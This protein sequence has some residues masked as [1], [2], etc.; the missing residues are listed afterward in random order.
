MAP[1]HLL[2]RAGL[3]L[4]R[5][6]RRKSDGVFFIANEAHYDASSDDILLVGYDGFGAR[7]AAYLREVTEKNANSAAGLPPAAAA[8]RAAPIASTA[9]DL[10]RNHPDLNS[11][12]GQGLAAARK[13]DDVPAAASAGAAGDPARRTAE[14]TGGPEFPPARHFTCADFYTCPI[15]TKEDIA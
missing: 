13:G 3:L 2:E 6:W 7:C 4:G 10:L 9:Y 11:A 14:D 1:R 8:L 5:V 12:D 15:E